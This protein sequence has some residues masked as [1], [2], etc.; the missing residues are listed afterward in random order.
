MSRRSG[1]DSRYRAARRHDDRLSY[2]LLGIVCRDIQESVASIVPY[3]VPM[4]DPALSGIL[5]WPRGNT[6]LVDSVVS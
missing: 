1:S 5:Y 4:N 2:R 3:G 6:R